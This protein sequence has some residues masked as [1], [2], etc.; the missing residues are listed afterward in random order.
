MFLI[1]L[2]RVS[3]IFFLVGGFG[4]DVVDWGSAVVLAV[5]PVGVGLLLRGFDV[6]RVVRV[7]LEEIV[8]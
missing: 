7:G 4:V 6:G 2:P 8:S 3:V 1:P 5:D